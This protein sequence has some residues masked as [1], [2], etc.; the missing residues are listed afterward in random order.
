MREY[1]IKRLDPLASCVDRVVLAREYA[2]DAWL[3]QAYLD[4]CELPCLPPPEEIHRL[5]LDVFIK[6]ATAREAFRLS[7]DVVE[8]A[9]RG[10]IVKDI[11]GTPSA[12]S[13]EGSGLDDSAPGEEA[14]TPGPASPA[15]VQPEMPLPEPTPSPPPPSTPELPATTPASD[16]GT[17]SPPPP[18]TPEL[19]AT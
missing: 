12:P 5:G 2:I 7:T 13:P 15:T 18:S 11:F 9:A 4:V 3:P 16:A 8:A 19:P 1:A 10:A 6:V 17:A 14:D